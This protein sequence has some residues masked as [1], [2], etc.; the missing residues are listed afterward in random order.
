MKIR[1][2]LQSIFIAT[3]LLTVGSNSVLAH[4][5]NQSQT[6]AVKP[7]QGVAPKDGFLEQP[8]G[9]LSKEEIKRLEANNGV[10]TD[11]FALAGHA[12]IF[13][14]IYNRYDGYDERGE[15][16]SG[17]NGKSSIDTL[18]FS[19]QRQVNN[20]WNVN[21]GFDANPVKVGVGYDVGW[22]TTYTWGYSA[23]VNPYKTVHI[24]YQ[25]WYHVQEYNVHTDWYY[26]WGTSTEY[27]QGWAAQWFKPHFYSWE[28]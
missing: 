27:G 7:I 9:T 6:T 5:E 3:L 16:A 17:Y 13:D 19:I 20:K 4:T 1:K 28:T 2:L 24:G 11:H 8:L 14:N 12:H 26:D 15:V 21:I 23:Q 22:S 18:S 10:Q 25:D